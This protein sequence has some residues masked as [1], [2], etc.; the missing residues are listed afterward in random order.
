M[1]IQESQLMGWKNPISLATLHFFLVS[2][3]EE[4]REYICSIVRRPLSICLVSQFSFRA[5]TDEKTESQ[6][7]SLSHLKGVLIVF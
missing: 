6:S 2:N 1:V 4:R 5:V 7:F 3:V